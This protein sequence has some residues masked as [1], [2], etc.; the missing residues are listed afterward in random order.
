MSIEP[1]RP[2]AR[3]GRGARGGG[4][5]SGR[6]A[7]RLLC[8]AGAGRSG[9]IAAHG[10]MGLSQGLGQNRR[11]P[12]LSSHGRRRRAQLG[13]AA[14]RVEGEQGGCNA[15]RPRSAPC[16]RAA[17]LT[18]GGSGGARARLGWAAAG[19]GPRAGLGEQNWGAQIHLG[20]GPGGGAAG[21]TVQG[22]RWRRRK[23]AAGQ[24]R[25]GPVARVGGAA[26]AGRGKQGRVCRQAG[27]PGGA[28]HELRVAPKECARR[29]SRS[30]GLGKQGGSQGAA[31]LPASWARRR[32]RAPGA[33]ASY[34]RV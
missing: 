13:Q 12:H 29:V 27:R 33:G 11:R 1:G 20:C 25:R 5:K 16:R 21:G 6:G 24:A 18:E 30:K 3:Q 22:R 15:A 2:G 14:A 32:A 7:G 28:G 19:G 17:P 26:A 9:A 4:A 31:W 34:I 23:G 8:E 10:W